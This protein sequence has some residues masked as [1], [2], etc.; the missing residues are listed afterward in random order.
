MSTVTVS[1]KYQIVIPQEIRAALKIKPGQK[2]SLLRV[3][4]VVHLVPSRPI[5]ELRGFL[6]GMSTEGF[7][8]KKD[9]QL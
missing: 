1:S 8:E 4:N 6:K 3:G 9:R 7:R 5:S 2:L